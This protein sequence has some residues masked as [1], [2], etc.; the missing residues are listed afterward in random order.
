MRIKIGFEIHV[1]LDTNSK[2]FCSCPTSNTAEP[3]TQTC[4]ICLGFPGSRPVLNEKAL[5][6]AVRAAKAMKFRINRNTFFSRKTYFY[7]DLAKSFQITQFEMPIGENG[8]FF[9]AELSR[10][11]LEEDPASLIHPGRIE[12]SKYVLVDYNRSGI[13][14]IEIVT[15]PCFNDVNAACRF[16]YELRNLLSFLKVFNI[17]KGVM[18]A[19]IN[20]SVEET[21]FTRVEIKNVG[22]VQDIRA[23]LNYEIER[24]RKETVVKETRSWDG[25]KTIGMR[26]KEEEED[27]GYI[28]EPDL[29]VINLERISR[30]E[31]E[32][33]KTPEEAAK[34][35]VAEFKLKGKDARIVASNPIIMDLFVRA[36]R[37]TN[38]EIALRW[39]IQEL[40]N[41]LNYEKKDISELD[42]D[43]F[44]EL[45][46]LVNKR[47]IT[48]KTGKELLIKLVQKSFDVLN[49][50]KEKKL[51][52]VEGEE[53]DRFCKES[54]KEN[55]KAVEQ[56]KQ[57]KKESLN[58]LV[59]QVMRKSKGKADARIVREA[60][61]KLIK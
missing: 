60:L 8:K 6:Y 36:A 18:K 2:L 47:E 37:E 54:I 38:K 22:S 45:I 59:G 53:V 3:N 35:L 50:V 56:Y 11:H 41:V 25:K 44:I 29:G 55:L 19:D 49:Y 24:Q 40:V 39:V 7:P 14:L 16:L 57:G 13:P 58:F 48:E 27:Y 17:Q 10:I 28:Y 30:E 32:N 33:I 43:E 9:G 51:G 34:E 52:L 42:S 1:Q 21:G 26:E 12:K 61:I 5:R 4:D 31:R 46:K 23:S 20:V 15:E